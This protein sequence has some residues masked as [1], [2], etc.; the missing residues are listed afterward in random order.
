MKG[1][2]LKHFIGQIK[3]LYETFLTYIFIACK[4]LKNPETVPAIF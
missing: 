2:D 4:L 3:L 1:M